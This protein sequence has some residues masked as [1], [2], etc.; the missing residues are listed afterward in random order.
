VLSVSCQAVWIE[1]ARP[2]DKCVLHR[3]ASDGRTDSA[4]AARHTPTLNA[5]VR[6]SGRLSSH[7]HT[8]HDKMI[9]SVSCLVCRC[10][11]DDR[12]ERVRTSN[13]LSAT[14]L[15]CPETNSHRRSGRDADKTVLLCLAWLYKYGS[16]GS[17][18]AHTH[19]ERHLDRFS[20][21]ST[22]TF[23]T[24]RHTDR[25]TDRTTAVTTVRIL[26]YA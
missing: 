4:C 22:A 20:R 21:F 14:V 6:W 2:P 11:L 16:M 18:C 8:R 3:S 23:V 13:F 26:C 25:Q 5:L 10:E 9:L 15:S 19:S 12:S 24:N 1:S 7:L 17:M